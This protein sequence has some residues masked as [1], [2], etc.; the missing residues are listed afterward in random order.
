MN[1]EYF[2]AFWI[3]N[4]P[5]FCVS[6]RNVKGAQKTRVDHWRLT[7]RPVSHRHAHAGLPRTI[8]PN[9]LHLSSQRFNSAVAGD[10]DDV[11]ASAAAG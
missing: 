1:I 10:N 7:G 9:S 2:A 6:G 11:T 4:F 3:L 5:Y 8:C